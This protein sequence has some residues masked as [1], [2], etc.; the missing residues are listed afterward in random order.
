[1]I[2]GLIAGT[3]ELSLLPLPERRPCSLTARA[4]LDAP[5]HQAAHDV[6]E[7]LGLPLAVL[8]QAPLGLAL[9]ASGFGAYNLSR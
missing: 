1:L 4:R 5:R 7:T 6:A 2:A 8:H 9:A 3:L